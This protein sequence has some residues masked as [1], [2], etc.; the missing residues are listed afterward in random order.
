MASLVLVPVPVPVLVLVLVL[1]L[2]AVL[3][4]AALL[5][6]TEGLVRFCSW[7]GSES[8]AATDLFRPVRA[9][10]S[11]IGWAVPLWPI[12]DVV[13]AKWCAPGIEEGDLGAEPEPELEPGAEAELEVG[14][15]LVPPIA[16]FIPIPMPPRLPTPMA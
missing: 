10:A 12:D 6:V 15:E 8:T 3:V 2:P 11:V 5:G 14:L 16:T 4:G 1:V 7:P 9:S 13:G